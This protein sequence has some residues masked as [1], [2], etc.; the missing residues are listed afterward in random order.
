[1]CYCCCSKKKR[2]RNKCKCEW[3]VWVIRSLPNL[4]GRKREKGEGGKRWTVTETRQ[5][6]KEEYNHPTTPEQANEKKLATTINNLATTTTIEMVPQMGNVLALVW[7]SVECRRSVRTRVCTCVWMECNAYRYI[8]TQ[9][10]CINCATARSRSFAEWIEA[11][12][13]TTTKYNI[14]GAIE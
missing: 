13:T 7:L 10:T 14:T 5:P 11:T 4:D 9:R 3:C 6:S 2:R 8:R 1:M 12:T